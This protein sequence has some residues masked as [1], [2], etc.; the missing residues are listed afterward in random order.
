MVSIFDN[1]FCT[2]LDF[3]IL[4]SS[5]LLYQYGLGSRLTYELTFAD[6]SD[7]IKASNTNATYTISNISL[8]LDTVINA[9]LAG[10]IEQNTLKAVFYMTEFLELA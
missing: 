5:L 4:E 9:S 6:Y 8:E 2:P 1:K 7:V 3:E 10:L